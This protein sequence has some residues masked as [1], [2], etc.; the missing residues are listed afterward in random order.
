MD[1]KDSS[2]KALRVRFKDSRNSTELVKQNEQGLQ[3]TYTPLSKQVERNEPSEES[4][5]KDNFGSPTDKE[6]E[7][8]LQNH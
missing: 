8:T 5:A 1:N 2:E 7:V 6:I 4:G 3:K